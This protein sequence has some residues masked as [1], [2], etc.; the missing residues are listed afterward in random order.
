MR[1]RHA[2]GAAVTATAVV[3]AVVTGGLIA[4]AETNTTPSPSTAANQAGITAPTVILPTGD[5]VTIFEDGTMGVKPAPGREDIGFVSM[6]EPGAGNE[7]LVIP[8]DVAAEIQAGHEDPRRYNVT[9]L[10]AA[11]HA[12]AAAVE[13]S[14]LDAFAGLPPSAAQA[15]AERQQTQTLTVTLKDRT[16]KAPQDNWVLWADLDDP[17]HWGRIEFDESG[18]GT[19]ELEPGE[20]ALQHSMWNEA[21]DTARGEI[22][23]GLTAVTIGKEPEALVIDAAEA[24][25]LTIEVEE[26]DAAYERGILTLSASGEANSVGTGDFIG[27]RDDVYMLPEPDLPGFDL[28][29]LYQAV[30]TGD[31]DDEAYQYNLA[32][33]ERGSFPD[34]GEFKPS[35]DHL[36][37][38]ETAFN[39]LGVDIE[40]FTC[41]Y[42]DTNPQL[43]PG[44][45]AMMPTS[46][47]SERTVY[48]TADP[49]IE[50]SGFHEGGVYVDELQL[51]D[52]FYDSKDLGSLE[53]G[54]T[55]RSV[56]QGPLSA[57]PAN[58]ILYTY[59]DVPF[60]YAATK[61]AYSGSDEDLTL[62]GHSARAV[63]STDDQKV[64]V[65]EGIDPWGGYEFDL[66]G[67]DEG[68]YTLE[69][70][71][72]KSTDTALLGTAATQTWN[73]DLDP[74]AATDEGT[75]L[76]LPVVLMRAEDV[77]G[78]FVEDE[79]E[80][81][82]TLDLVV[83]EYAPEV[84]ATAMTLEVSFDD[85]L[86][87]DEVEIDRDGNSATGT[88]EHPEDAEYASVR[89]TAVDD[90]G[91]EVTHTL[92]RSYGLR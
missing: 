45:C 33:H 19:V 41:D 17:D 69:V 54:E 87:W 30:L 85:G 86:T 57:G 50:W 80:L 16:G 20:Y 63:L 34:E 65:L 74:A 75:T 82:V 79:D 43:G 62:V 60:L 27:A 91:T 10:A 55:D 15:E 18:V 90:A 92:I 21:T 61:P 7:R 83:N 68:R 77:E 26:E 32:F 11:G 76:A 38:E 12:D 56:V 28:G 51:V 40:G 37:A 46:F 47:P 70:D 89:M 52:G 29:F 6:Y 23:A 4:N 49:E 81:E 36:A 24:V 42:G 22:V 44:L 25:P 58:S 2:I 35:E 73:F 1:K 31:D 8:R 48:Y 59:E 66:T 14:E 9:A 39:S 5:A 53:A 67:F 88:I 64:G 84:T 71:S 3:G 13:E 72:T 78:G